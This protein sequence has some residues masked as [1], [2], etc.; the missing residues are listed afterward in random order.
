MKKLTRPQQEFMNQFL[1]MY[2]QERCNL[3]YKDVAKRMGVGNVS[4]YEMLRL[5]EQRGLIEATYELPA[6]PRG[7]GRATVVF[8][9]TPLATQL[10][11]QSTAEDLSP[12]DWEAAKAR[13]L[14]QMQAGVRESYESLLDARLAWARDQHSPLIYG[15]QVIANFILA[16]V[17]IGDRLGS[18]TTVR[19]LQSLLRSGD[20]ALSTLVG[21]GLGMATWESINHRVGELLMSQAE[22]L[23]TVI[24]ELSEEGYRRLTEFAHEALQA[25]EG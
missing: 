13:I 19:Q 23:Q 10:Y 11:S 15:A 4:A 2:R 12:A 3:H 7:P 24:A 17:S 9:P 1:D 22:R 21:L 14:A 16:L 5:L 6:Q 20:S 25:V 18:R 8:R